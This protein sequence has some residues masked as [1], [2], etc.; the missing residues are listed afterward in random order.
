MN[1]SSLLVH[2]FLGSGTN[3][4]ENM[5]FI[6]VTLKELASLEGFSFE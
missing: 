1:E 3:L 5:R 4:T 2:D 6:T